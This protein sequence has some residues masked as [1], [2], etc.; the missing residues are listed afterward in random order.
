[1]SP[2]QKSGNPTKRGV[3]KQ[4]G[5]PLPRRRHSCIVIGA[6]LAGLAAAYRLKTRGWE[7]K[8]LDGLPRVGGRVFS[9]SFDDAPELVCELGG[10]WIGADHRAM[11]TLCRDFNLRLLS[12]KYFFSFWDGGRSSKTFRPA[13]WSFSNQSKEKF[14][15]F[16]RRFL[17]CKGPEQ[18]DLDQF[19]W[20]TK[21]RMLGFT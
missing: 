8:V 15:A 16:A 20:W 1:M 21:L 19:D 13:G 7:V 6:G 12:H 18:R 17:K 5:M 11:K 9:Y 3:R 14:D 4:P 10:E 2:E